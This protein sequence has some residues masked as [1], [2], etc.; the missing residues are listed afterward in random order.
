MNIILQP[1]QLRLV[2]LQPRRHTPMQ[3]I[4]LPVMRPL[5]MPP[6]LDT[7][8]AFLLALLWLLFT[9]LPPATPAVVKPPH[10]LLHLPHQRPICLR[11][12][13]HNVPMTLYQIPIQPI[14]LHEP[15]LEVLLVLLDLIPQTHC[16]FQP[17]QPIPCVALLLV[18]R[19]REVIREDDDG[20]KHRVADLGCTR[21]DM[22]QR[23]GNI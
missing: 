6:R 18:I 8:L 21:A 4:H 12:L 1:L 7:P 2:K 23:G 5:C 14:H 17:A 13:P 20:E 15:I 11:S 9:S 19:R 10:R 16:V 3:L 22:L